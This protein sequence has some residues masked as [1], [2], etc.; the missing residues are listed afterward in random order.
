MGRLFVL[1]AVLGAA[2]IV[3]SAHLLGAVGKNNN[4]IIVQPQAPQLQQADEANLARSKFEQAGVLTY[5]PAD[6]EFYFALQLRVQLPIPTTPRPRDIVVVVS[7]SASQAGAPWLASGQV[8][9]S[10]I[11]QAQPQDRIALWTISTPDTAT[12]SLTRDFVAP[13]EDAEKLRRA[14]TVLQTRHFPAG[15]TD[16]K[17]GLRQIIDAFDGQIETRQRIILFLGDGQ[18]THNPM[19]RA[20]RQA[21][22]KEMVERKIILMPVPLGS[23]LDANNLHG[24]PP[25]RAA[26]YSALIWVTKSSMPR[27]SVCNPRSPSPCC[28]PRVCRCRLK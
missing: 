19:T 22:C 9:E 7:N 12:A 26:R 4:P 15:A 5:K 17:A 11:K 8:A 6:G 2:A 18:S 23:H 20:D 21:L 14:L 27:C 3:S 1:L 25:V 28:T 10:I 13:K 16:L 24:W